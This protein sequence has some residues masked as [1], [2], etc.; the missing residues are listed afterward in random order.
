MKYACILIG[1]LTLINTSVA[2]DPWMDGRDGRC[3]DPWMD[4]RW[5]YPEQLAQNIWRVSGRV[6]YL[7]PQTMPI[8]TSPMPTFPNTRR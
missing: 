5:K 4:G 6:Y 3:R 2:G 8:T 7:N 1:L